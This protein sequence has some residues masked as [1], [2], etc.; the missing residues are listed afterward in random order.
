[1]VP[2]R[3]ALRILRQLAFAG[4]T[5][6]GV[7]TVAAITY[8]A[9]RRATIAEK[10]VKN[11]RTLQTS[12]PYYNATSAAKKLALMVE[13]AE[14]GEY[15]GLASLKQA[16]WNRES[17]DHEH[18]PVSDTQLDPGDS[19]A[20]GMAPRQSSIHAREYQKYPSHFTLRDLT[21]A[22]DDLERAAVTKSWLTERS[23]AI[24]FSAYDQE[25]AY[26][27]NSAH[28]PELVYDE[29]SAHAQES[30][31]DENAAYDQNS[32]S[33]QELVYDQDSASDQELVS[34]Q[35]S[36]SD[37]N[38]AYEPESEPSIHD[39]KK[40]EDESAQSK[41][42]ESPAI[43]TVRDLFERGKII[44][45]AEYYLETH[46]QITEK[47]SEAD[48]ERELAV[49]IFY[50]NCME[51]NVWVARDLF[52]YIES[53]SSISPRMWKRLI[54]CLTKAQAIESAS[55]L[56]L[57]YNDQIPIPFYF[58]ELAIRCLLETHRFSEA[59]SIL[60]RN[61][62]KDEDCALCGVYLSNLWKKSRS[63]DLMN[64]E[65]ERLM[66]IFRRIDRQPTAKLFNPMVK[67]YVS[68]GRIADAEALVNDM[69]TVY[70]VAPN[71]RTKGLLLLGQAYGCN[72]KEVKDGL[73]ELH[74]LGMASDDR[75]F[76]KAYTALFLEFWPTHNAAEIREFFTDAVERYSLTPDQ[77][78]YEHVLQAYIQKGN[79]N[80]VTEL[81]HLAVK[82][83]WK[84]EM[85]E[86]EF[87]KQLQIHRRRV[88]HS[89]VGFWQLLNAARVT[90]GQAAASQQ[91]LG[92][93]QRSIP[94][95]EAN[96]AQYTDVWPNWYRR[97]LK[98]IMT[99]R[100]IDQY[101][102]LDVQMAEALHRGDFESVLWSYENAGAAGYVFL[103]HH[104]EL[105]AIATLVQEG[106]GP[107]QK[108]VEKH[109]EDMKAKL[110]VVPQFFVQIMD[111]DALPETELM[112]MAVFRFYTLCWE[113]SHRTSEHRFLNRI[114]TRYIEQG[115]PDAALDL[116]LT[117]YK[118]RWGRQERLNGESMRTIM[119][120]FLL[121]GSLKGVRWCLLTTIA[122]GSADNKDLIVDA[123]RALVTAR[124]KKIG[125]KGRKIDRLYFLRHLGKLVRILERK[126]NGDPEL[127]SLLV[128]DKRWRR[129]TKKFYHPQIHKWQ[130]DKTLS[131]QKV[132]AYWDE[133]R[134]LEWVTTEPSK[135]LQAEEKVW[136]L[137]NE[138]R[139]TSEEE[140]EEESTE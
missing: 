117:V 70:G 44:E 22:A 105:A 139:V 74:E 21:A 115:K 42:D 82:S 109:W 25:S 110:V 24:N 127:V 18:N 116:M 31:Y 32:A 98:G 79:T 56:I 93:D 8:D 126:T 112:K 80:F 78:L 95:P 96:C 23:E 3:N 33:D 4:S 119:R 46:S 55:Q 47:L 75:S 6:G 14:A 41:E 29:Y 27:H 51:D 88:E 2:S 13:A 37:Q 81:A 131:L 34:D 17:H 129:M 69:I 85:K 87:V 101:P 11:K 113:M 122:R 15:D 97:A 19:D 130:D 99:D 128:N 111:S 52:E 136:E 50:A 58:A 134:E 45:A 123:R 67:A 89:P 132:I 54:I 40:T 77:V 36:A 118:S 73:Q 63:I 28:D 91:I 7:C 16:G 38:L 66:V 133:E 90:Y 9:H 61:V 26:N 59:A 64:R 68:F 35:Y 57:K 65:F 103:S 83:G 94:W 92:Y 135:I 107:A 71:C 125:W 104:V 1:M 102:Q 84:V 20:E 30:A 120:A 114:A 86:E 12:T 43:R 100:P 137:W 138:E 10:I 60:Y 62:S 49:N 39:R 48:R 108:L 121:T 72:W 76:V 106:L 5:L 124:V 140:E 53:R